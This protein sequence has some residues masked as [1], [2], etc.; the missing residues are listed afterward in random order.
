MAVVAVRMG[1]RFRRAHAVVPRHRCR[2]PSAAIGTGMECGRLREQRGTAD[3]RADH[4]IEWLASR[5][6]ARI[7]LN[8]CT[9]K[10]RPFRPTRCWWYNTGPFEVAFRTTT[11]M[12]ISGNPIVNPTAD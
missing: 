1:R 5:V 6:L 2:G 9:V 4:L 3:R 12:A 7:G 8:L 10:R 11:T